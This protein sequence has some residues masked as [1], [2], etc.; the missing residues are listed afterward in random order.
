ML[1]IVWTGLVCMV[2]LVEMNDT[3]VSLLEE[4]AWRLS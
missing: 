3:V 4:L 1:R 2:K